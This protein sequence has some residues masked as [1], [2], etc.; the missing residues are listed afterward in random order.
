MM[1]IHRPEFLGVQD[2]GGFPG[3][4]D[5]IIAKHR[6][7]EVCDVKMRFLSSEVKFVDYNDRPYEEP[8]AAAYNTVQSKMNTMFG[9]DDD[10]EL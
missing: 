6:N 1:F 8:A 10:F 9:P 2:E 5:L 3:E 4:T 7:G